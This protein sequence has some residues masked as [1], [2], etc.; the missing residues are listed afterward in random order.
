MDTTDAKEWCPGYGP[1]SPGTV[2]AHWYPTSLRGVDPE[3]CHRCGAP[4]P[5]E[6]N[7]E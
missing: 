7:D 3:R 4:Q 6:E 2:I 1:N 5:E